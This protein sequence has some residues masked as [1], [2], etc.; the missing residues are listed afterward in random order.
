MMSLV[1]YY[2]QGGQEFLNT[3]VQHDAAQFIDLFQQAVYEELRRGGLELAS[4]FQ[5]LYTIQMEQVSNCEKNHKY[6]VLEKYLS[7]HL[8]VIENVTGKKLTTLSAVLKA[9]FDIENIE[10]PCNY[11]DIENVEESCNGKR[12][13]QRKLVS[14]PDVLVIQLKRFNTVQVSD[15]IVIQKEGHKID[16]IEQID[17]GGHSYILRSFISHEGSTCAGGH[18][19]CI[20]ICEETG[21]SFC[22]NDDKIRQI[23]HEKMSRLLKAS[24]VL[25]YERK[26]ERREEELGKLVSNEGN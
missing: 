2:V 7:L 3:K 23:S 15:Q 8:N 18:Y 22:A 14:W 20:G 19:K 25:L 11:F 17:F 26:G 9:Y 1:A 6:E 21:L 16:I 13:L 10:E 24:Y 12:R 5:L 4:R